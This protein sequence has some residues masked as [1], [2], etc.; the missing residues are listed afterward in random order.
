M[1]VH[2]VFTNTRC[3]L[4]TPKCCDDA[5]PTA[6]SLICR[7][8]WGLELPDQQTHGCDANWAPHSCTL[9]MNPGVWMGSN[10]AELT[11]NCLK[12]WLHRCTHSHTLY[13]CM[14]RTLYLGTT[15]IKVC[16]QMLDAKRLQ[17]QKYM[18]APCL[19]SGWKLWSLD[20]QSM[21][22]YNTASLGNWSAVLIAKA[23]R[24]PHYWVS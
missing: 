12:P 3:W 18:C 22:K 4:S 16:W 17:T 23:L 11:S 2:L 8:N 21:Q 19:R 20:G 24:S 7:E 10:I 9:A 5:K 14:I 1:H 15:F 6:G 13:C